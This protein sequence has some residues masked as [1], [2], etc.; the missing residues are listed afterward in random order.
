MSRY[1]IIGSMAIAAALLL[2]LY[3]VFAVWRNESSA[4]NVIL[5]RFDEMGALQNQNI[6]SIRGFE[7]GHVASIVRADE[8]ALVKIVLDKPRIF[9]TDTRFRN[10]S[11]NIMGSRSIAVELGKNGEIAPDGYIFDGEFEPG[12]AE[13]LYMTDIAKKNV[14]SLMEFI[15]LLS[16]GDENNKSLQKTYQEIM[17]EC[18]KF[19]VT[20][21]NVVNSVEK[22]TLGA[23]DKV[24]YYV[25]EVADASVKV[26][27]SIDT[28][29]VQAQDGVKSLESI[30]SKIKNAI[31]NL[32][33][34]LIQFENSP[35][36]IAIMDKK[37]IVDDI[38]NLRSSL[39]TFI[40][41]IDDQGIKIFDENGKRI[42]MVRLKN[43]HLIRE[44]ARSKAKKRAEAEINK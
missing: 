1:K 38:E 43:I 36:T 28:L 20:L 24:N 14:A 44:T 34:I 12:L 8:K 35:V 9:R 15:Y 42:S 29:R 27:N 17:A 39:Q 18:E 13:I 40:N 31:K 21:A 37:E 7:V 2:I 5:V 25:D 26:G 6:V 11:P 19:V 22:Q 4:S 33:D 23:L 10:V 3:M 41:A 16:T 30:V 32:D